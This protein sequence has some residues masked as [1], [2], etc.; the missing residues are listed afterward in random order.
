MPR[1]KFL[2]TLCY[3][4]FSTCFATALALLAIFC[5]V[6]ARINTT[7]S[8]RAG[9]G[10]AGTSGTPSP[11]AQTA[12]Y[13][14]SASAVAGIWLFFEIY[15][16]NTCRAR[17][18]QF[19]IPAIVACIFANVSMVYAPQ[20]ATMAQ[21]ISF[22][23]RLLLAF[24]TGLGIGTGVSL[25]VFPVT[26]RQVVFKEMTGYINTLRKA[27]STNMEFIQ[28]LQTNDM[29]TR[30]PTDGLQQ[31]RNPEAQAIKDTL[32][33][34]TELHGK[35]T[36]DVKISKREIA[37]GKL[38]PDDI[39]ELFRR[40]REVM[41]PVIGLSSLVDVFE[42]IAEEHDWSTP[43]SP[44]AMSEASRK[45]R[46]EAVEDWHQISGMITDPFR[47]M[48]GHIDDGLQHIL[49]T[50]QLEQIKRPDRDSTK[51]T[52]SA[53]Q[54]P[55]SKCFTAHLRSSMD[56][57]H[58]AKTQ[59]ITDYARLRGVELPS[60]FFEHPRM[61]TAAVPDWYKQDIAS[62]TRSRYRRQL[63]LVLYMYFLLDAIAGTV[64]DFCDYA[65]EKES[66][67]KLSKSRLV[68]PGYKRMR[69]WAY[70]SLST[71]DTHSTD[72]Q[73]GMNGGGSGIS[74]VYFGRAY[75]RSGDPEHLPPTNKWQSFGDGIRQIPHFL[76][77]PASVFG[78]R[79][80]LAT[81]SLAIVAYLRDTQNFY[82]T[83]RLFWAQIMITIS[84]TPSAG[85]SVFGF[86]LRLLGTLM[87]CVTS[88]IIWYIVDGKT[89][90]VLVMFFIFVS[91]GIYIILKYPKYTPVGMI[92]SV[93]NAL[94]IGYE[95]QVRKIGIARSE[96]NGQVY[97]PL[98]ELA[99]YRLGT[100]CAGIFVAWIWTMFPWPISEHSELRR[101]L[102]SAL[103]LL[104]NYYSVVQETVRVRIQG[105]GEL[106]LNQ[107]D[108]PY[109]KLEKERLKI[110]SKAMLVLQSL[111]THA[112]FVK[113]DFALGGKFPKAT[114]D[115][116]IDRTQDI[117]NFV[118]LISYSSRTFAEM[119]ARRDDQG[120]ESEWLADFRRLT[121]EVHLSSRD[122][123]AQ[124]ALLSASVSGG[125]PLPPFLTAPEPF[126]FTRKL[127]ALDKDI[128]SV[129][130]IAEPGY[131]AFAC[132]QIATQCIGEDLKALLRDVKELVGELDFSFRIEHGSDS[133]IGLDNG[134]HDAEKTKDD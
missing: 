9:T 125:Q 62:D 71:R 119:H 112:N 42:R 44:G 47:R 69:K 108:G 20:F 90:G 107:K 28:S 91:G 126:Q 39:Q 85:Q 22:A 88:F 29:F 63:Y 124:L 19:T 74:N 59:L 52:E 12:G 60:D 123:T 72:E 97:Y 55:G 43:S 103:Y 82:V 21:G 34:L 105:D 84:M 120:S 111:R 2:E 48:A 13:N 127:D 64:A 89:A 118:T 75:R 46:E 110:F 117:M 67:G 116:I 40:L 10:G 24:L 94:I 104:A 128:L 115:K 133:S 7:D 53:E 81:M 38:G 76:R 41:L 1:A 131:A 113:F 122:V 101:D 99:P 57:F 32:R 51:D 129:R 134:S 58:N 96:S 5:C 17:N 45:G 106:L 50:L 26:M 11:G 95:L 23:R 102:G 30:T 87:A 27:V 65:D 6:H 61:H 18:P 79:V 93:T 36:V 78:L 73:T 109:G 86:S 49:Y 92:Y 68:V 70:E 77:S 121:G 14:S 8:S 54:S 3:L 25:L 132:M 114:Y 15:I 31:T 35:L 4:L 100:V 37:R 56:D 80:A 66:S 16:I 130:H 33:A 98:Y 83:N